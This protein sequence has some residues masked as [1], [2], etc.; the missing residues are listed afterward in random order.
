VNTAMAAFYDEDIVRPNDKK[1][2]AKARKRK[3]RKG[4]R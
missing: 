2:K 1:V 3:S 4:K